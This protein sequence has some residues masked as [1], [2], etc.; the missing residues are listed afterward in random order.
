MSNWFMQRLRPHTQHLIRVVSEQ[1]DKALK[2]DEEIKKLGFAIRN[3]MEM[4]HMALQMLEKDLSSHQKSY[5]AVADQLTFMDIAIFNELSQVLFMFD[6]FQRTSRSQHF[7]KIMQEDPEIKEEDQL[8]GYTKLCKW[9]RGTM[10]TGVVG[11]ALQKFDRQFREAFEDKMN[12][13]N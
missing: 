1:P 9:Y 7:K 6:Y 11:L 10:Q 3:D 2:D 12:A 4:V 13:H 8:D 5:V